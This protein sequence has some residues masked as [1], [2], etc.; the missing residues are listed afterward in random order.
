MGVEFG[1]AEHN[2]AI[3]RILKAGHDA[4]KKVAIFCVNGEQARTRL[5]QGFD[6]VS[7]STDMSALLGQMTRELATAKGEAPAAKKGNGYS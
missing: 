1:G 4:G 2:A 7:V 5:D 6:L 3:A